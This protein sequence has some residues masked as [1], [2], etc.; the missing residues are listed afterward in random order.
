M[1]NKVRYKYKKT[2]HTAFS[3]MLSIYQKYIKNFDPNNI[4]TE[5]NS[6]K[7]T[8]IYSIGYVTFKYLNLLRIN[9]VKPLFSAN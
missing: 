7:N 8:L 4:K 6:Y 1:S 9:S 2:A 5:E 3:M